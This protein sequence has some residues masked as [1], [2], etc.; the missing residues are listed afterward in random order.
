MI[1]QQDFLHTTTSIYDQ[2]W[3]MRPW[4]LLSWGLKQIGLVNGASADDRLRVGQYVMVRN[5]EVSQTGCIADYTNDDRSR[6]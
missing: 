6:K 5:V 4:G 1:P 2:K 3:T